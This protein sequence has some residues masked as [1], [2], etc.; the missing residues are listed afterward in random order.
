M[1]Y[2]FII[3]RHVLISFEFYIIISCSLE[4]SVASAEDAKDGVAQAFQTIGKCSQSTFRSVSELSSS[5]DRSSGLADID[6]VYIP[7]RFPL[8]ILKLRTYYE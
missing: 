8:K 5:G 1:V 6:M 7:C 2:L 4:N 3:N